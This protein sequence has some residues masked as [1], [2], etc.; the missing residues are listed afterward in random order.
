M[1]H[2]LSWSFEFL[3]VV[4][5]PSLERL[6]WADSDPSDDISQMSAVGMRRTSRIGDFGE[7]QCLLS[8][9]SGR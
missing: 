8:A 4:D 5:S 9:K 7:N 1:I 2:V 3:E 6:Q